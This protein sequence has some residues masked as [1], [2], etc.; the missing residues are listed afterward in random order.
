VP[1]ITGKD[2]LCGPEKCVYGVPVANGNIYEWTVIGGTIIG[3]SH[4]TTI[5]VDW[6]LPGVGF[7]R[8]KEVNAQG[9]DTTVIKRVAVK[10]I[11]L[12]A[13][14]GF[15]RVCE[16]KG[17]Y[18]YSAPLAQNVKYEWTLSGG[19][20]SSDSGN[21][22]HV[23]WGK[24]GKGYIMLRETNNSG[25]ENADTLPVSIENHLLGISKVMSNL[26]A[27]AEAQFNI[28]D[29]TTV[30]SYNW[31]FGDGKSSDAQDVSHRYLAAGDYSVRLIAK[32]SMGCTD[33]TYQSVKLASPPLANFKILYP[34]NNNV[35]YNN[36]DNLLV[37]NKSKYASKY[38]WDFGDGS[39]DSNF[40]PM[41]RLYPNPGKYYLTL[42]AWNQQGCVDTMIQQVNVDT[43]LRIY[44]PNA[45]TPDINKVN[46]VFSISAEG[47]NDFHVIIFNRWGEIVYES[48]DPKFKWDGTFQGQ[49]VPMDVYVYSITG[50]DNLGRMI[51][52]KGPLTVLR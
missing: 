17:G 51:Y 3:N 33:T 13:I 45:F 23:Y 39:K 18:T 25:C 32:Y 6:E 12:P 9:C 29:D 37:S 50:K 46:P 16:S 20:I 2:S 22:I 14:K 27:P 44:I 8:I 7:V 26:C 41:P 40:E 52:R 36:E 10:G 43:R 30:L 21:R 24:P 48:S 34:D 15:S 11:P 47:I 31:S 38:L 42:Y 4:S 1:V 5:V 35:L 28:N 49:P 19:I